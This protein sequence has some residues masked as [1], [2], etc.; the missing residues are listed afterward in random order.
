MHLEE[1]ED[2]VIDSP[3]KYQSYKDLKEFIN[4]FV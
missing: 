4:S 1:S 3:N 2:S